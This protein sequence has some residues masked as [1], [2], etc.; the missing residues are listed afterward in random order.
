[1]SYA[2]PPRQFQPVRH[3]LAHV[4]KRL[5]DP[6]GAELAS[7]EA[8]S[9]SPDNAWALYA[10]R[11]SLEGQARMEEAKEVN[12]AVEAAWKQGDRPLRCPCPIFVV[13]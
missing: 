8:L 7:R 4:L 1:M 12:M 6:A 11:E 13:F 5:D 3:C 9:M 2:E 10:L